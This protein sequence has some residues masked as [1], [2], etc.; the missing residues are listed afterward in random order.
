MSDP[1]DQDIVIALVYSGIQ[2]SYAH[3]AMSNFSFCYLRVRIRA[4]L[5]DLMLVHMHVHIYLDE[6]YYIMYTYIFVGV[7]EVMHSLFV[8]GRA[9]FV[10]AC[11]RACMRVHLLF[12]SFAVLF[13]EC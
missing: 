3:Q 4:C 10:H 12:S 8:I 2:S 11:E 9:V 13:C 6:L 7:V 1:P 5:C